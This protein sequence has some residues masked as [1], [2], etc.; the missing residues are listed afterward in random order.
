[1]A[2]LRHD[3]DPVQGRSQ[4]PAVGQYTDE[5]FIGSLAEISPQ[6]PKGMWGGQESL[7]EGRERW[8]QRKELIGHRRGLR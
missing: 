2:L 5:R 1:M 6:L 8:E 7:V 3:F 4:L